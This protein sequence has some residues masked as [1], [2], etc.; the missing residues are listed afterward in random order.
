MNISAS[1][2]TMTT[3]HPLLPSL[4]R[5]KT[6]QASL[7]SQAL[8]GSFSCFDRRFD[9]RFCPGPR[10]QV[11]AHYC[12][13][14]FNACT[15]L[16]AALL[17]CTVPL[18]PLSRL[19]IDPSSPSYAVFIFLQVVFSSCTVGACAMCALS[20]YIR[21]HDIAQHKNHPLPTPKLFPHLFCF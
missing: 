19:V 13:D 11:H 17:G 5:D 4:P 16:C 6:L 18:T 8:L 3:V 14:L 1:C 15:L 2:G 9:F 7:C 12:P 20:G 21:C 10:T